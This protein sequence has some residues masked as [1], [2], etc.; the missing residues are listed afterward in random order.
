MQYGFEPSTSTNMDGFRG[1]YSIFGLK[2]KPG[3]A[4]QHAL[5]Y[6]NACFDSSEIPPFVCPA[7]PR[8]VLDGAMHKEAHSSMGNL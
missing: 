8:V 2:L 1:Y 7:V 4:Q 5:A 3:L 6:S